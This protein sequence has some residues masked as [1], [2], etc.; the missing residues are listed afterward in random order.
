MSTVGGIMST[1]GSSVHWGDIVSTPGA[2]HDE[3][4]GYHEYT[5]GCSGL[6]SGYLT[7]ILTSCLIF[8]R[9]TYIT[10]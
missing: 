7:D 8:Q 4:G 1:V 5:G 6:G 2:Y 3:Y 9:P 10:A